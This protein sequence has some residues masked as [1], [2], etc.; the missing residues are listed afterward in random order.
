M[1]APDLAL[2]RHRFQSGSLVAWLMNPQSLDPQTLMP[3]FALTESQAVSLAAFLWFSKEQ[4]PVPALVERLPILERD[5]GWD[6]VFE[7]VFKNVC[8]HC[9]S[10]AEFAMG[11]GGAGNT[12]GFGYGAKGFDVSSYEAIRSG[13]MG[14]DGRRR[15]VFANDE[16]GVPLLLAVLLARRAEERGQ[17]AEQIGM[18]LGFPSMSAEQIQLVE[19]WI[20]QGHLR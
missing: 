1:L 11:D 8:W 17:H 9:H 14:P 5:V 7:S 3:N 2:T 19:S 15:S 10:D 16:N 20:A 6:E 4:R 12:G 18:P 13:A